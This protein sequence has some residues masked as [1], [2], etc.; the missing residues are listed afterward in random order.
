[1]TRSGRR[2]LPAAALVLVLAAAAAAVS[3]RDSKPALPARAEAERP[4][5]LLLTSLPIVF[6]ERLSLESGASPALVALRSRYNVEPISIADNAALKGRRLL[7]MAQPRAQPAEVLVDLDHW[8][9]GGGRVLLL[10]DP[11]LEWPSS[12]PLGNLLRPPF[13]FADTGLL[14]H[15]ALRLDAPETLGRETIQAE[16]ETIRTRS[17]GTLVATGDNCRVEQG[18]IARCRIG[19]GEAIVIADAD[20]I[21]VPHPRSANLQL[22]LR[23][24]DRLE[25]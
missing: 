1:M 14:A 17:P 5:L 15:W 2:W 22:L 9:R 18:F 7:L 16:G 11:A 20:F 21:D 10:A 4:R 13:A 6:P 25:R 19:K 12:R 3:L 23:Q 8:V 24:L